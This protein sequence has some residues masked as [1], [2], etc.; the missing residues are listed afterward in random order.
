MHSTTTQLLV[1]DGSGHSILDIP[2][3]Y[4][5]VDASK[6]KHAV[7]DGVLSIKLEK[8]S[9]Q[10]HWPALQPEKVSSIDVKSVI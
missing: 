1:K 10:E 4:S 5:T 2:Q 7:Q 3:L 9:P 6:T 8:L